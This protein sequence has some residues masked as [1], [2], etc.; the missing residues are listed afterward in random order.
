M[1]GVE[2]RGK[3]GGGGR[4]GK[5]LHD[6]ASKTFLSFRLVKAGSVMCL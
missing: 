2:G 4:E 5:R 1:E 6:F 3:K